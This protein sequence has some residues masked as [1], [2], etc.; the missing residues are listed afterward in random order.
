[1]TQFALVSNPCNLKPTFGAPLRNLVLSRGTGCC[2]PQVPVQGRETSPIMGMAGR[3]RCGREGKAMAGS[4]L[5]HPRSPVDPK[6]SEF[7]LRAMIDSPR[8]SDKEIGRLVVHVAGSASLVV[9]LLAGC[10]W[11]PHVDHATVALLM[12]AAT[13]ALA[14]VW[15]RVGALTSAII[16]GI[17]FDYYFLPP[18]GFGIEK[19]EHLVALTAFLFVAVAIGQVA[20]RSKHLLAQ[21]NSLL[22]LSLDPLCIG[23]LDG[24]F[25]SVNQAMVEL[26]G[27]SDRE[28][29]SVPFLEFVHPD[30]HARTKAAFRN[31]SEG[32]SVVDV[33]NRY[34]TKDG[35]WRWLHWKIAPPAAGAS[36]LSAAAHDVTEE[37]WIQEKLRDLAGQV[38]TAQEE[39]RRRIAA[40]LHDD[41]TQRLATLGIEL[42]LLKRAPA[43][44]EALHGELSRLQAQI[45]QL[46]DD[47]R[48]LSHS[49]HPSILEHSDLA[50]SLE[51][52]CL[53]FTEQHGI[54]ASFTARNV[55]DDV[56]RPVALAL[57]RIAQE[58]LR[59]VARHSG[60]TTAN[61]VL[62]G[63]G[64]TQLS[65]FVIDNGKGFEIGKART[66][67]GLGLVSIEERARHIGASVTMDSMPDAGTRLSVQVPLTTTKTRAK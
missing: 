42:G 48:R 59:N 54:A 28:L 20:A 21:R 33:E 46:S 31:F 56:P 29:C 57:Y 36:W 60:A 19:P 39:E 66:S 12:I 41:V 9:A 23:D 6:G 63:E 51:M 32:R 15:G 55:P 22:D 47:V 50:A 38:M 27:W 26:L 64:G 45:L 11:L 14:G 49:L 5:P 61:V 16:G 43:G 4:S 40:E 44:A 67:P 1:V 7:L 37:K 3:A 62:A 25:R 58:S 17:G 30:D 65:L 24:N 52:H 34:R 18:H 8:S 35:D 53:E 10:L 13:V 2:E